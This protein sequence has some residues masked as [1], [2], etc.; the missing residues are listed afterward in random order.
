M[1]GKKGR[2]KL[3][4]DDNTISAEKEIVAREEEESTDKSGENDI[5]SKD[6]NKDKNNT[7]NN[8]SNSDDSNN[9][10]E[11]IDIAVED[12]SVNKSLEALEE[13]CQFMCM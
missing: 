10:R 1:P 13:F 5:T 7:S 2:P 8:T 9:S 3:V 4:R 6:N 11:G 12:A